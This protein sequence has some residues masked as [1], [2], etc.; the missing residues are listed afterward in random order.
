[1]G[2]LKFKFAEPERHGSSG[3]GGKSSMGRADKSVRKAANRRED[4]RIGYTTLKKPGLFGRRN[5]R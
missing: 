1:M 4:F 3:S 5:S 2:L